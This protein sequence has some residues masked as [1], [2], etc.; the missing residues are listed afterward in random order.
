MK[1]KNHPVDFHKSRNITSVTTTGRSPSRGG[2]RSF[3]KGHA[4]CEKLT[5]S[6]L[7]F[8]F[9]GGLI[10]ASSQAQW[11]EDESL[12]VTNIKAQLA[13]HA[14]GMVCV[15]DCPSAE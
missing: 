15:P 6:L 11:E 1:K 8:S 13:V 4:A 3:G 7:F 14:E 2:G 9:P 12:G 10:R 5:T